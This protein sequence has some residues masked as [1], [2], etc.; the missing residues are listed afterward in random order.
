VHVH[1]ATRKTLTGDEALDLL[2]GGSVGVK[3]FN[4]R[5][6]EDEHPLLDL[7]HVDLSKADLAGAD[8]HRVDLSRAALRET[9][10]TDARLNG[11]TLRDADMAWARLDRAYMYRADL[12]GANLR[13]ASLVS[14]DLTQAQ[15]PRTQFG[16][17]DL[18]GSD[19][20]GANLHRADLRGSRLRDTKLRGADLS[21]AD[22]RGPLPIRLDGNDIRG[23]RFSTYARDPWSVLRRR[24]T[25]PLMFLNL[26]FLFV[27]VA[28]YAARALAWWS[29]HV[30]Q[31]RLGVGEGW[32][33]TRQLW[34]LLIGWDRGG[35]YAA[36]ALILIAY[37]IL[38]GYLTRHLSLMRDAE[39]RTGYVP[40][41]ATG[42]N[43]RG[44]FWSHTADY[45]W[46]WYVHAHF[47]RWVFWIS[48]AS[49]LLHAVPWLFTEIA[50]PPRVAE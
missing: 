45:G 27:F 39:E 6:E 49:F 13:F 47:L 28:M 16:E 17:S 23:A 36:S 11:S 40:N 43:L 46:A 44:N 30:T 18:T 48:V 19:L 7:S 2:R 8:L 31:T 15:L 29:L 12:S 22:L 5:R 4:R 37:N 3:A 24:Y 10:L 32:E 35:L 20:S 9:T 1:D 21:E 34:Q 42:K 14:A 33:S 38:R 25:G 50:V 41:W 26:A